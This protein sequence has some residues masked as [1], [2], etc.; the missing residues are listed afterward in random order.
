MNV[1]ALPLRGGTVALLALHREVA[2][3]LGDLD[4]VKALSLEVRCELMTEAVGRRL[5]TQPSPELHII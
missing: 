5:T 2:E 3:G 4:G 1:I